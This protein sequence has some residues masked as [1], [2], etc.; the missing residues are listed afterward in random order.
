MAV[1]IRLQRVGKK[2]RPSYRLAVQDRRAKRDGRFIEIVGNYDPLKKDDKNVVIQHDRIQYWVSQGAQ[3]SDR[4]QTFLDR[5]PAP[6][7][8]AGAAG[9]SA[10]AAR[11]VP[12]PKSEK[13][14]ALLS[15]GF[16]VFVVFAILTGRS[17]EI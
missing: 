5:Y 3:V 8:V 1:V 12:V 11:P 16:A 2:N 17:Q 14:A 13:P 10:P 4:I 15:G 7:A 9:T 6:A